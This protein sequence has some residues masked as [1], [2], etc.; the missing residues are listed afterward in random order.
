MKDL[1][2]I[3]VGQVVRTRFD[4]REFIGVVRNERLENLVLWKS[5]KKADHGI[6]VI[7]TWLNWIKAEL[8]FKAGKGHLDDG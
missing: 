7:S 8:R 3:F 2:D 1:P 4:V 6:A 5:L